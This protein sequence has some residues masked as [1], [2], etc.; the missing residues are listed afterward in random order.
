MNNYEISSLLNSTERD[1][2]HLNTITKMF[3][4]HHTSP[5]FTVTMRKANT[6]KRPK[7]ETENEA[8]DMQRLT[9]SL[10]KTLYA[11]VERIAKRESRS[12]AWVIRKGIESVIK[13]DEPLFNQ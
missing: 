12:M 1:S 13:E 2:V 8:T 4:F 9:I 5:R 11:H 10:P 7:A 3:T 6:P